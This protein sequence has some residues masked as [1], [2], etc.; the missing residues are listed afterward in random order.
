[1]HL[2]FTP[3]LSCSIYSE[4]RRENPR[5]LHPLSLE[6]AGLEH[7][8]LGLQT[9]LRFQKVRPAQESSGS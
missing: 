1:M 9:L 3:R 2:F 6:R 4:M 7:L 8:V 5:P